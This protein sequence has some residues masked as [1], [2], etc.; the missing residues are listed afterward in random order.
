MSP[1]KSQESIKDLF[2]DPRIPQEIDISQQVMTKIKKEKERFFVKYKVSILV[3]LGLIA[4]ISTGVAAVQYY[5]LKDGNGEVLYEEKD[6]SQYEGKARVVKE[7][8]P[9]TEKYY[10]KRWQIEDS[11]EPGTAA[12][13]YI[14]VHNP[15]KV[16]ETSFRPFEFN[17]LADL[18]QKVGDQIFVPETLPGGFAF[19]DAQLTYGIKREF[20]KEALYKQAEKDKK[21]YVIQP[22]EWTNELDNM[23]A[24]YKDSAGDYLN[25]NISHFDDVVGNT[26]YVVGLEKQKKEVIKVGKIEVLYSEEV[27][28]DEVNISFVWVTEASGKKVQ[29]EVSASGDKF[30]KDSIQSFFDALKITK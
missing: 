1:N 24:T 10:D 14:A 29:Y 28:K 20:D 5:Q 18:R 23:Y 15:K 25:L 19:S 7:L 21:E 17:T 16:I 8:D 4:S 3:A 2:K 9:E 26:R 30:T 22:L 6:F 11:L 13:V 12:A 27:R